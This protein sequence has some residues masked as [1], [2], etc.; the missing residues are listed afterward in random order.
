MNHAVLTVGS[1]EVTRELVHVL[2][3]LWPLLHER[4]IRTYGQLSLRQLAIRRWTEALEDD[5]YPRGSPLTRIHFERLVGVWME[6]FIDDLIG[7]RILLEEDQ[8]AEEILDLWRGHV[9]Q[10]GR[11]PP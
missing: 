9:D 1:Q 8:D 10:Q 3:P 7:K 6:T 4:A 5:G 11:L 2:E